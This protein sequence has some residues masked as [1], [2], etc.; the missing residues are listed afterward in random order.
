MIRF[1]I[2]TVVVVG[3]LGFIV[4]QLLAFGLFMRSGKRG[5][6]DD[7]ED[8]TQRL[9][10]LVAKLVPFTAGELELLSSQQ[11]NR[12]VDKGLHVTTIGSFDS[13]YHEPLIAFAYRNYPSSRK[14]VMVAM[15]DRDRW[16]YDI[17]G[18]STTVYLNDQPVG[19]ISSDGR[20][21]GA[22]T[23]RDLAYINMQEQQSTH[24][25]FIGSR[26]I[27]YVHNSALV[28]AV[29]PRAFHL[30]DKLEQDEQDIFLSLSILSMVEESL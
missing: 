18:S 25:I 9:E 13:I 8:L 19:I 7:V 15:T 24:A 14:A 23:N 12:E 10:G 21:R 2:F 20:L 11:S 30:F 29:N 4:Y 27:G 16:V 6:D 28:D 1:L 22:E 26:E 5:T 17:K 3:A